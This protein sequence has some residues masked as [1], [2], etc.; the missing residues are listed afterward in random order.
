MGQGVSTGLAMIVAEELGVAWSKV[1]IVLEPERGVFHIP[2]TG[3][4][5]TAESTSVR[6]QYTELRTIGAT[7]REL[8][9]SAAA[10]R[11]DVDPASLYVEQGQVMGGPDGAV[12]DFGELVNEAKSIPLPDEVILKDPSNFEL[13]GTSP[14]P[15]GL[16]SV[17]DG[18][19]VFGIDA[20]VEGMVYAAIR[21]APV[22]GGQITNLDALSIDGTGADALIEVPGGIAV[23]ATS[24]WKANQVVQSLDAV[25]SAPEEGAAFNTEDY[26]AALAEAI[27]GTGVLEAYSEGDLEEALLNVETTVEASYEVPFL[28][29]ACMEPMTATAHAQEDS[30]EVWAPTQGASQLAKAVAVT[31]GLDLENV[32]VNRTFLGTGFGR[33]VETD[34]GVQAAV[35]SKAVGKPVKLIWSREEDIKNDFYRPG[36][37]CRLT[38]GVNSDGQLTAWHAVSAG[39]S[40]LNDRG[41]PLP[42]DPVSLDGLI[43][44]DG[45]AFESLPYRIPNQLVAHAQIPSPLHCGFWRSVGNSQ[46][47]FFVESFID[48]VALAADIDPLEFRLGLLSEA[49]RAK[50]VVER[51]KTEADWGNPVTP[52]SSQGMAFSNAYDSY[53]ALAVEVTVEEGKIRVHRATGVVDCG[54]TIHPDLVRGQLEGGII[55]G[56]GAGMLNAIT[57]KDGVVEQSNFHNF[58]MP[59]MADAPD[60]AITHIVSEEDPGGVGELGVGPAAPAVANAVFVATGQRLRSL[61][62]TLET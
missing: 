9:I 56:M 12:L 22:R 1:S 29:H 53:F 43:K 25:F 3:R 8:L 38:G 57:V 7:A 34:Y 48:E 5:G 51:L 17:V 19:R 61:P 50:A 24:Y 46:N 20:E 23:V 36:F 60:I 45:F 16:E 42:L 58:P 11:W 55:F 27:E 35:I 44:L 30:C 14:P 28:A 39:E 2:T 40:I 26:R 62:L 49:P 10:N 31:L 37:M 52:G 6:N 47:A 18:T 21:H 54:Q 4:A 59:L 15:Q 13:I 41:I 32:V 33:K